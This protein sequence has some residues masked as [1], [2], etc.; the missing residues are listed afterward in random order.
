[1][2]EPL[3]IILHT[4]C[5]TELKGLWD[6]YYFKQIQKR[7]RKTVNHP[8]IENTR[9]GRWPFGT[10]NVEILCLGA[11]GK[12]G[13]RSDAWGEQRHRQELWT[14]GNVVQV[15]MPEE[16]KD[17]CRYYELL[18]MW[19][20]LKCLRKTK[21]RA[22]IMKCWQCGTRSNARGEQRHKQ[23]L[24]NAGNVAQLKM[25]EENKDTCRNYELLVM[26]YKFK[27]WGEQ[28]HM[29]VLWTASNVA[30]VKMPEE[31]KDTGR[32]YEMLAMWHTFKC[33]RTKTQAGIMKC[34]HCSTRSNAWGEQRHMQEV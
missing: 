1:M 12:Y 25:P 19:H 24:W 9:K 33:L 6:S 30:Q 16:N 28:R 11:H 15:Q 8:K 21:T 10:K 20:K 29:Q 27:Y 3:F 32:N 34:W 23:E 5:H 13:T 7:N 17:T 14:A 22:G 4:D 26:L 31:N 18:A 2:A